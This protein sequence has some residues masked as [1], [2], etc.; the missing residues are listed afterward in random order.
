MVIVAG[1]AG[2]GA[3]GS[4]GRAG[5]S[6]D[7]SAG[8]RVDAGT[9]EGTKVSLRTKPAGIG[10]VI[11]AASRDIYLYVFIGGASD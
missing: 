3:D 2:A 8:A 1:R 11:G 7:G 10:V 6:A 4:A 9:R 5:A